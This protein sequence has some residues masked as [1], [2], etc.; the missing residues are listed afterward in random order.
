MLIIKIDEIGLVL[1]ECQAGEK[2]FKGQV[3]I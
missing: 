2:S 1:C 3:K